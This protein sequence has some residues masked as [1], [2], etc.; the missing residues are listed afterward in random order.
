MHIFNERWHVFAQKF[1]GTLNYKLKWNPGA[2]SSVC[3]IPLFS[4]CQLKQLPSSWHLKKQRRTLLVAKA[5]EAW[6]WV[7]AFSSARRALSWEESS[8]FWGVLQKR[9]S[10]VRRGN[11]LFCLW[12][13]EVSPLVLL[14]LNLQMLY[15]RGIL[16]FH[17]ELLPSLSLEPPPQEEMQSKG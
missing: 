13:Q 9:M 6:R 14:V 1:S 11:S 4:S 16:H 5:R 8:A 12:K 7:L 10:H 15:L 3:Q 2:G 17:R